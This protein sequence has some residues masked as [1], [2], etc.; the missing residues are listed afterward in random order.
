L[1]DATS[2]DPKCVLKHIRVAKLPRP[3]DA[4]HIELVGKQ[5]QISVADAMKAE[6]F[7][8][9]HLAFDEIRN[10]VERFKQW[11]SAINRMFANKLIKMK[12]P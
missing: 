11:K 1:F 2:G 7:N 3:R 8:E 12:D 9:T 5:P 10:H 6:A 4:L